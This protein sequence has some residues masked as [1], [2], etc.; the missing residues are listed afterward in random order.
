MTM[1]MRWLTAVAGVLTIIG[2]AVAQDAV[3]L[4]KLPNFTTT[5]HK[6]YVTVLDVQSRSDL[7]DGAKSR[8]YLGFD[9][10]FLP[11]SGV[12]AVAVSKDVRALR[13]YDGSGNEMLPL[14]ARSR[15][16]RERPIDDFGAID[17]GR[18]RIGLSK[19]AVVNVPWSL[20]SMD[21]EAVLIAAKR[22]HE[23]NVPA[24]VMEDFADVGGVELR[25]DRLNMSADRK[26]SVSVQ[27]RRA[28]AGAAGPFVEAIYA[29]DP[30][31]NE[32]GG[33][34]WSDGTPFKERGKLAFDF[35][36]DR[37]QFHQTF[38]FVV[39]NDYDVLPI[40]FTLTGLF[41]R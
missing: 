27:Y 40:S 21:V 30:E 38:K 25:I 8:H 41:D 22:R 35:P 34:R 39:C 37:S 7:T 31:G 20:R 2:G 29:V 14:Q 23:H 33:G 10:L 17:A 1:T 15:T 19:T 4:E 3:E 11:A 12:D 13:M 18:G 16:I 28:G 5:D 32:L 9:G 6:L 36:L 26:L 24:A